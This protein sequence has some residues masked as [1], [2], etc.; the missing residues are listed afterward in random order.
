MRGE[1]QDQTLLLQRV[2]S[3][4]NDESEKQNFRAVTTHFWGM[5]G[6]VIAIAGTPLFGVLPDAYRVT[7]RDPE[8]TKAQITTILR[9]ASGRFLKW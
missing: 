2:A 4:Q 6:S 9:A 8:K 5:W 7:Q 1:T 3:S